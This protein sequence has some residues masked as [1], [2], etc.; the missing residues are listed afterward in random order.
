MK[1][2]LFYILLLLPACGGTDTGNPQLQNGRSQRDNFGN[3]LADTFT[4]PDN[5]V[6]ERLE[7][8]DCDFPSCP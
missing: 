2:W 3:C 5:T 7:E 6:L 1:N 8:L 4:C